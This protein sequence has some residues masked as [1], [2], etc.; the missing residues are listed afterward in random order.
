MKY[1]VSF[2]IA[3]IKAHVLCTDTYPDSSMQSPSHELVK[4]TAMQ[5]SNVFF[6]LV[7]ELRGSC[8]QFCKSEATHNIIHDITDD[9]MGY[10]HKKSVHLEQGH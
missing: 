6:S 9:I 4:R 7:T 3:K 10:Q 2:S 1:L 5:P 8:T